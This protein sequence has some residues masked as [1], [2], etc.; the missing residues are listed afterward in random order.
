[1]EA[2]GIQPS[3]FDVKPLP[4]QQDSPPQSE[5]VVVSAPL[6]GLPLLK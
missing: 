6:S 3:G 4:A 5:D 1:M 2:E